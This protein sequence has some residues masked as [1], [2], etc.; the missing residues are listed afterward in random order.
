MTVYVDDMYRY[1]MGR[2]GRMKMSHMFADT[3]EE[4]NEMA[5]K[6]GVDRK[7]I[8]YADMWKGYIHYDIAMS[9][10]AKAISYGAVP[11][12]LRQMSEMTMK[13]KRE[14]APIKHTSNVVDNSKST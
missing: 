4:L 3:V 7:W 5:D 10:R 11:I 2:F 12:T 14:N 1:P 6:I 9:C 13:W 8:Q